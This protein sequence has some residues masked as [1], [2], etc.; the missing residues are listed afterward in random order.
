[1]TTPDPFRGSEEESKIPL[2]KIDSLFLGE[3]STEEE[4]LL[5]RNLDRQGFGQEHLDKKAGQRPLRT[6]EDLRARLESPDNAKGA[7]APATGKPLRP[8]ESRPLR[9]ARHRA[10]RNPVRFAFAGLILIAAGAGLWKYSLEGH[11]WEGEGVSRSKGGEAAF[12]LAINGETAN[13]KET[14]PA[15]AGDTLSIRYRSGSPL[16]VQIWFREEEGGP[17]P[18]PGPEGADALWP[19][20]PQW[21]SASRR[22]LLDGGWMRQE[23]W[24]L[25]SDS[26]FGDEEALTAIQGRGEEKIRARRFHLSQR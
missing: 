26:P 9:P 18:F 16:Y 1:M 11:P 25:Y 23:I 5:R 7:A 4:A 12:A 20:S 15:R 6:W 8:S 2:W 21:R 17:K 24:I 13:G 3:L 22:I 14:F 19:A 10:R